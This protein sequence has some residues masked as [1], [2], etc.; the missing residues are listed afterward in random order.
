MSVC[1]VLRSFS[2]GVTVLRYDGSA[3]GGMEGDQTEVEKG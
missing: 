1:I 2:E 3:K